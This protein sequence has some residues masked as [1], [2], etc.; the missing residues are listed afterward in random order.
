MSDERVEATATA[1]ARGMTDAGL[2]MAGKLVAAEYALER[3]AMACPSCA[4]RAVHARYGVKPETGD[5][6]SIRDGRERHLVG[7]AR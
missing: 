4:S 2:P 3:C 6:R 5:A 1:F 7:V